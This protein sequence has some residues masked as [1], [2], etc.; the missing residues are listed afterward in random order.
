[1]LKRVQGP[2]QF[3]QCECW[4]NVIPAPRRTVRDARAH[5]LERRADMG[6]ERGP[7]QPRELVLRV[8]R[9][10]V[11]RLVAMATL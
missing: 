2:A 5:L 11:A 7:E 3:T 10:G 4:P 9:I 1:M 8:W 6:P